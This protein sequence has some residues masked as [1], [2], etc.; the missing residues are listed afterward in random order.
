[1][2]QFSS[3]EVA[4]LHLLDLCISKSWKNAQ[5]AISQLERKK[6]FAEKIKNQKEHR[7]VTRWCYIHAIIFIPQSK[8]DFKIWKL[9]VD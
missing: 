5:W 3:F 7:T 2:D 8:I 4:P 6:M 1:M 9:Q